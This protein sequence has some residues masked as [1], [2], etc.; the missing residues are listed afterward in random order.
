[1]RHVMTPPAFCLCGCR[2]CCA[3]SHCVLFPVMPDLGGHRHCC[4]L[5][6]A[7]PTID[8]TTK[9][10]EPLLPIYQRGILYGDPMIREV[11][12]SGLAE[13]MNIT[14]NKYLAGPLIIKI[15]GPLLRIVGDRNPP[16]VKIAI[17]KTLGLILVKGGPALR[18]FV[19]QFQTTFVKALSDTSRQVRVEAISAL[20]LL[21]P[22]S[23]RVDPLLKELV[24][25]ALGKSTAESGPI[26]AVQTATLDALATVVKKGGKKAKL[27]ASVDSALDAS[28]QLLDHP[29]EGVRA[30][31]AKVLGACCTLK[32]AEVTA[33]I[34]NDE[35]FGRDDNDSDSRHAKASV[36]HRVMASGADIDES[37]SSRL[38]ELVL[39][40]MQ[41]DKNAVKE[42]ACVAIGAAVACSNN[43]S[44]RLRTVE[45]TIL[46]ILK[47]KQERMEVHKALGKG[48]CLALY[49]HKGS[50]TV[51]L[52]G[53]S[54]ID[55]CVQ[56]AM[57][58][59]QRIQFVFNDVLWLVFRVGDGQDENGMS[60]GLNEYLSICTLDK[61]NQARAL[62]SKI[63]LRKK[64]LDLED[65]V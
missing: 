31:A 51:S 12:A 46:D 60:E 64:E 62:Q 14:A 29:D 63:L 26:A 35:I 13:V 23:T 20:S 28:K 9:G 16:N 11:A 8:Q 39:K 48:L 34:I 17:L 65:L 27:P 57:G 3:H 5:C 47:N 43:P 33:E 42:A 2:F 38:T 44:A 4:L 19:P 41:D 52:F 30:S 21:M 18:A 7:C 56:T 40:Y 6:V 53:K 37:T 10:I 25:G 1:M 15:T 22:L 58:G 54:L 45:P 50:D 59:M 61:A 49:L 36:C 55:Q 32:G 24:A